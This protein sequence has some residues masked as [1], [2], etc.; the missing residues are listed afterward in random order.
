MDEKAIIISNLSKRYDLHRVETGNFFSR[1]FNTSL[2]NKPKDTSTNFFN[3]LN[4]INISLPKGDILGIIGPNGSGKSTLLKILAGITKPT[5]GE[6]SIKGKVIAVLEL[7]IGF[8]KELSGREN[9]YHAAALFGLSKQQT[10]KIF[11]DVVNFS[12]LDEFID[13]QVKYYSSGMFARLAFSVATHIEGD[14]Y[15]FDEVLAVGDIE[16]RTR[17]MKKIK[18]LAE[19]KKTV[20]L[21]SHNINEIAEICTT[22]VLLNKGTVVAIGSPVEVSRK[23]MRSMFLSKNFQDNGS[24]KIEWYNIAEAP[25]NNIFKVVRLQINAK[26]KTPEDDISPENI[27]EIEIKGKF[28]AKNKRIRILYTLKDNT[29]H[30]LF[31]ASHELESDSFTEDDFIICKSYIPSGLLNPFNFIVDVFVLLANGNSDEVICS[32]PNMLSFEILN[33]HLIKEN[34]LREIGAI[35]T[36]F[37]WHISSYKS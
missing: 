12:G 18:S 15:L 36:N 31:T 10:E 6:V 37:D 3:A 21:V 7:G 5:K 26:G 32:I 25:G 13:I 34:I 8:I 29:G 24:R 1:L 14:I 23:M 33:N 2:S 22:S 11:E 27:I 16:F 4:D 30:P 9:V 35:H 20:V 19:D 28:L 17:A